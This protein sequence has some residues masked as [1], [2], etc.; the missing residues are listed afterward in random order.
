MARVCTKCKLEIPSDEKLD[1][2][3]DK[4]PCCGKCWAGWKEYRIMVMNE[5]R[6]DM[7]MADHRKAL[8]KYEK[9]FVGVISPEGDVIDY[10]NEENRNP[11]DPTGQVSN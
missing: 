1:A 2:Q 10:S 6:L 4:Y 5:M 11:D 3:A 9:V 8:R 7:S